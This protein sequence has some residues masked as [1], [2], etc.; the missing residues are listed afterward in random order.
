MTKHGVLVVLLIEDEHELALNTLFSSVA[1]IIDEGILGAR[2]T[3]AKQTRRLT[4]YFRLENVR[5]VILTTGNSY[6]NR[7]TGG[8]SALTS[9]R[10]AHEPNIEG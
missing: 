9:A 8:H 10:S 7:S 1:H 6:N 5:I 2:S 4:C 3:T